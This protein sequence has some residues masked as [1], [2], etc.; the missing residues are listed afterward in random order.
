MKAIF[1]STFAILMISPGAKP[2][3]GPAGTRPAEAAERVDLLIDTLEKQRSDIMI[4]APVVTELLIR[5]RPPLTEIL[6]LLQRT[7]G[8]RFP[9]FDYK[10]AVECGVLLRKYWAASKRKDASR[11]KVKFD[12]QIIAIACIEAVDVIYSDDVDM[13]KL[14]RAVGIKVVGI[15]DLPAKPIDPQGKLPLS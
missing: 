15:W 8:F 7:G 6:A 5:G 12:H 9:P 10:T 2:P 14:G 1:D 13:K 11:A 3:P 4:P